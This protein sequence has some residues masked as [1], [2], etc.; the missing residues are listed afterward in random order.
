MEYPPN[1][2]YNGI[3]IAVAWPE[4]WGKQA[5]SWYDNPMRWLGIN[6]NYYYRAGHAAIILIKNSDR[7][8][9]Y[10]DFGRFHTPFQYGRVRNEITDPDLL[11]PTKAVFSKGSILNIREILNLLKSNSFHGAGNLHAAY[12]HIHFGSAMD[13]ANEMQARESIPFGPFLTNGMNCC[14]FVRLVL[15]AGKPAMK[16]RFRLWF[17][18][19]FTPYPMGNIYCLPNKTVITSAKRPANINT[20]YN[21]NNVN[22][23][24]PEPAKPWLLPATIH[25]LSGEAA[26][27]WF[28]IE[29]NGK[30][31]IAIRYSPEGEKEF[32]GKFTSKHGRIFNINKPFQ[33]TYPSQG[34]L[35]TIIQGNYLYEFTGDLRIVEN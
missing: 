18:W 29:G 19:P 5:G 1:I 16:H 10:F 32:M 28:L 15:L 31:Y 6:R 21:K 14:R 20:S 2:K 9:H 23:T 13:R 27:S 12:C 8:C 26:G 22:G 3:A 24:L 17:F 33:L 7:I 34:R 35:I 30:G 25:W 11:I 4:T